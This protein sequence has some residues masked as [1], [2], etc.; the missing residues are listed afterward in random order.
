MNNDLGT[1]YEYGATLRVLFVIQIL[2]FEVL[3]TAL[4]YMEVVPDNRNGKW[5]ELPTDPSS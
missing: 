4:L 1:F 5:I 2:D 3:N